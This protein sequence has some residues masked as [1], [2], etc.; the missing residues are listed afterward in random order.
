MQS[1]ALQRRGENFKSLWLS[2]ILMKLYIK[3]DNFYKIFSA[4]KVL[5]FVEL[6]FTFKIVETMFFCRGFRSRFHLKNFKRSF[7]FKTG[8]FDEE[9][10]RRFCVKI[11]GTQF[12]VQHF[13]LQ[14]SLKSL[15][16]TRRLLKSKIL[17]RVFSK[18]RVF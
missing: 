6:R 13:V 14:R 17:T 1:K 2:S 8:D 9:D 16:L 4:F 5:Y 18:R 3:I 11:E 12:S 15:I 7:V 10:F